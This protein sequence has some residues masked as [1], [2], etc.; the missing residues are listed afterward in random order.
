M[1]KSSAG[2]C[3]QP[4]KGWRLDWKAPKSC[5]ICVEKSREEDQTPRYRNTNTWDAAELRGLGEPVSQ[6]S[7]LSTHR[8]VW[9]SVSLLAASPPTTNPG[10]S[11]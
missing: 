3:C 4:L 10:D 7:V 8:F 9:L 5:L 2:K 1:P 11:R 6:G